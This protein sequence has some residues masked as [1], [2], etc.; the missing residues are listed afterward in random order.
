MAATPG[1]RA[2]AN[3]SGMSL[4][5]VSLASEPEPFPPWADSNSLV[6]PKCDLLA[7]PQIAKFQ[8]VQQNLSNRLVKRGS[9][10]FSYPEDHF[11]SIQVQVRHRLFMGLSDDC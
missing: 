5:F 4:R 9:G 2:P 6:R 1:S 10:Q 3:E 8:L 7:K 11:C